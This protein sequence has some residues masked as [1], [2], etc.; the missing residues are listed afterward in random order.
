MPSDR[1]WNPGIAPAIGAYLA[2]GAFPLYWRL[3]AGVSSLEIVAHRV[4]WSFVFVALLVTSS[5][6]W[7]ALLAAVRDRRVILAMAAST[8]LIS[9]NWLLF[10]WAVN[11]GHV[12]ETSLGYY[13]N[14]LVNVVL[15]RILLGE[16][17][18]PV[19]LLAVS[20]AGVGVVNLAAQVGGFPWVAL[21]LATSFGFYGVVRK[22]AP[23]ESLE[24][25][26]VETALATPIA[27]AY[28][29]WLHVGGG[30][31]FG[32]GAADT[33][34]L[35]GAGVAT[36]LPLLW[37][38]SAA[39]KLR[40]TTMGILQYIAPTGQLACAILVFGEPFTTAH[41][42]TFSFIWVAL[43]L[44]AVDGIRAAAASEQPGV[45]AGR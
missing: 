16:R 34:F 18:R 23:V 33:V 9:T 4:V 7:P 35:V 22:L 25:L 29:G 27:L 15:A 38:A 30:A 42:I 14:P 40:Y 19:Q 5:R 11:G 8:A 17:L 24:A 41:A 37:F 43:I 3:L 26:T 12:T 21:T 31:S 32:A 45:S 2:W 44:Y 6:R 10:I 39:R 20:L 1:R 28:V 36:A 13:I